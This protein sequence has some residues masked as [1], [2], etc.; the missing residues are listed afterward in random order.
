MSR[1]A[2]SKRNSTVPKPQ[3]DAME[4]S[5]KESFSNDR[6]AFEKLRLVCYPEL[7]GHAQHSST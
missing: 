6:L 4:H 3:S 2:T 7:I 1:I 5:L